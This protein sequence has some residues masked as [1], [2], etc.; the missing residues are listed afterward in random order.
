VIANSHANVRP[1][2]GRTELGYDVGSTIPMGQ[3]LGHLETHG[4]EGDSTGSHTR[5]TILN[6]V[7]A[8]PF[9]SYWRGRMSE[10]DGERNS[11]LRPELA[12]QYLR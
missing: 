12:W 3:R 10:S 4:Y 9:L 8:T 7:N 2:Q 11:Y 5:V 1:S 6:V